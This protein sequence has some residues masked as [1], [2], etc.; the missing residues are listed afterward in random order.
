MNP[1][2][3]LGQDIEHSQTIFWLL[4]RVWPGNPLQ[5][6]GKAMVYNKPS[7]GSY[8]RSDQ[9]SFATSWT[10]Y[11]TQP[12]ILWLLLR[13]WPGNPLQHIGQGI[14]NNKPSDGS[15]DRSIISMYRIYNPFHHLWPNC[16]VAK[17]IMIFNPQCDQGN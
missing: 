1:L 5:H 10:R 16:K 17:H 11:R 13:V 14:V 12:T 7:A 4:V 8:C 15:Y 9:E 2:Q 6:I 3:H